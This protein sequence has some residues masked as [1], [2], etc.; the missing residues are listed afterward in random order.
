M[1]IG[2]RAGRKGGMEDEGEDERYAVWDGRAA[3]KRSVG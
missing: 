1:P 3:E 2:L